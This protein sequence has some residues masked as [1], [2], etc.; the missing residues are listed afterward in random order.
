MLRKLAK[1]VTVETRLNDGKRDFPE[2]RSCLDTGTVKN[3][4]TLNSARDSGAS[5]ILNI[6]FFCSWILIKGRG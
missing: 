4:D 6:H 5:V 1:I 2:L 3:I